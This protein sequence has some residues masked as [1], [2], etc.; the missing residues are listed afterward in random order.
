MNQLFIKHNRAAP[1]SEPGKL[2]KG[3][4][5][6]YFSWGSHRNFLEFASLGYLGNLSQ[7]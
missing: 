4:F 1:A 6:L 3:N 7:K 5:N 2:R